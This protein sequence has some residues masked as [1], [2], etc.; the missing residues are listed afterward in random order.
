MTAVL[1]DPLEVFQMKIDNVADASLGSTVDV[2]IEYLSGSEVFAEYSFLV[3]FAAADL[4]LLEALP[5]DAITACGWESFVFQ[6]EPCPGCDEQLWRITAVADVEDGDNHPA[7]LSTT[8]ELARLRIK[9]PVDTNLAGELFTIDFY[10]LDCESNVLG[11]PAAD[12]TYFGKFIF[13]HLGADRTGLDPNLGGPLPGCV[14][15]DGVV[16][17]RGI[18]YHSGSVTITSELGL[19]GDVNGDGKINIS[20][21]SYLIRYIY[22][23]GPPPQDYLLGDLNMDGVT[24]VADAVFLF[25]YLFGLGML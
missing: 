5:G 17:V 8:G 25:G 15:P 13:D 21:A 12:T 14:A 22:Y 11:N 23:A 2:S 19:F 16:P 3:S 7:C 6:Q 9:M 24:N 4:Q 1:A 18:N 10:W 20:D